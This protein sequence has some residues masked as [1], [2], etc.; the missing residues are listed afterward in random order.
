MQGCGRGIG[1]ILAA[2][3][4]SDMLANRPI[5]VSWTSGRWTPIETFVWINMT[6]VRAGWADIGTEHLMF[7]NQNMC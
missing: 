6:F 3:G 2:A 4:Q 5:A 1:G 7:W